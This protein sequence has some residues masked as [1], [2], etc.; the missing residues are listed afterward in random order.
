MLHH[1]GSIAMASSGLYLVSAPVG[2]E[3][4]LENGY[5]LLVQACNSLKHHSVPLIETSSGLLGVEAMTSLILTHSDII[6]DNFVCQIESD[7]ECH[8]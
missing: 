2:E 3:L 1:D 8:L 6:Q 5:C 7:S 4:T